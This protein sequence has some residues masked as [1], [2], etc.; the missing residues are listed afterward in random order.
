M[1]SLFHLYQVILSPKLSFLIDHILTIQEIAGIQ[2][3]IQIKFNLKTTCLLL[4]Y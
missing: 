3:I 2:I 4:N 1:I